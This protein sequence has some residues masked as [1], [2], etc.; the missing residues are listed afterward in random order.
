MFS[1]CSMSATGRDILGSA[2]KGLNPPMVCLTLFDSKH[3]FRYDKYE[4]EV[5]IYYNVCFATCLSSES[6]DFRG[7]DSIVC[8]KL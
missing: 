1:D 7:V 3:H 5:Y 8:E 2:G 4:E 6:W